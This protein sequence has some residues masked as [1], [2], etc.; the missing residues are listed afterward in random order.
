VCSQA[1]YELLKGKPQLDEFDFTK[2]ASIDLT[3]N[4]LGV[5][6]AYLVCIGRSGMCVYV[7]T[8]D[9]LSIGRPGVH[10]II[11]F[12]CMCLHMISPAHKT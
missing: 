1:T 5:F 7:C 3:D 10:C 9:C 6:G 8:I 4:E 2:H 12:I 11:H